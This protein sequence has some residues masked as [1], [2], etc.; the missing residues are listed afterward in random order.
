MEKLKLTKEESEELFKYGFV[1]C[2]RKEMTIFIESK[3][4]IRP[5]CYSVESRD[6]YITVINPYW[7]IEIDKES[8]F[9][10]KE[11][12]IEKQIPKELIDGKY[13]PRCGSEIVDIDYCNYCC[14]FCGQLL[15]EKN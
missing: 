6:L 9:I 4:K 3:F 7:E 11:N 10:Y 15:K 12:S 5:N 1:K 14:S 8:I 2:H 13:C